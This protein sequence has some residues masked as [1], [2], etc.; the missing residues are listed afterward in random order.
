MSKQQYLQAIEKLKAMPPDYDALSSVWWKYNYDE[1]HPKIS[2]QYQQVGLS[3]DQINK[4]VELYV[5]EHK[6]SL[7][8]EEY[9][10]QLNKIHQIIIENGIKEMETRMKNEKIGSWWSGPKKGTIAP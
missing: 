1:I 6:E 3:E 4:L 7:S 10:N 5:N 2:I 9:K 8:E